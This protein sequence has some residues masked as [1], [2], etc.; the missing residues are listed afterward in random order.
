MSLPKH[1]R[2]I[3]IQSLKDN[4]FDISAACEELGITLAEFNSCRDDS[5]F[6]AGLTEARQIRDDLASQKF[7]SLIKQGHAGAVIEYQKML[8]QSDAKNEALNYRKKTMKYLIET[9]ETKAQALRKFSDIFDESAKIAEKFY[10]IAMTEFSL[11]SPK[12]RI[13][14]ERKEDKDKLST[15]FNSGKLNEVSM[16]KGLLKQALHDAE[17]AEYP[18]ERAKASEQSIKLT[19]RM[20]EI[21]EKRKREAEQD[22]IPLYLK[23]DALLM[24]SSPERVAEIQEKIDAVKH[25]PAVSD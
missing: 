13:I 8:R 7:M 2:S 10:Q 11:L 19:Q 17:N 12:Q 16:L 6:Q 15:L 14:K 25:L 4:C 18:S 24:G 9:A 20:D 3:L 21:E 23:V 1:T 5:D 22:S